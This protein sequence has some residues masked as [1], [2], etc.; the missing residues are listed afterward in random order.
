M[1]TTHSRLARAAASFLGATFVLAACAPAPTATTGSQGSAPSV[2]T[3]A[4]AAPVA[5]SAVPTQSSAIVAGSGV[6]KGP[7]PNEA[8]ALNGA[9]ATFPAALY[10]KWFND[11]E[12]VGGVKVNYQSIGSGGGIKSIQDQTVD[13][14]ATDGPMT[15]DQLKDAKGGKVLHVP[16]ALGAVVVTYN[17]PGITTPLQ[18]TP[19]TISGIFLGKIAKWN[20]PKI[21]A[22]NPGVSLPN[23]DITT[24]HRSD[25]SGTT[26]IW[27]DYLST[28]SPEWKS[29]VGTATSVDWPNGI[30][31]KGNEGVAGEVKQNQYSIGYVELIYALQ[32]KLGVGDVRNKSGKFVTPSLDSV[33]AAAAANADKVPADLRASIVD[34]PGDASYPISG[35][36]WLLVY[37]KQTDQAK[38]IAVTRLLWWATHDGQKA[39]KDLGYAPLPDDIIKR[40]EAFINSITVNGSK[41]FPGS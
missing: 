30:G 4:P 26:Y 22:D 28:I 25:G 11:Y 38:A 3:Q 39:N 40:G 41:A 2:A 37:E 18:F 31:G 27:T 7:N 33:T 13:F 36:T 29:K 17:L 23:Q 14:G 21:A 16:A 12:K 32:N 24:V 15:D 20:D 9:G 34:A 5:P 8:K 35:F 6:V 10:S 1:I 19:D